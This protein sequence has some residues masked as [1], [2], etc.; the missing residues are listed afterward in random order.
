MTDHQHSEETFAAEG[1]L[2]DAALAAAA[3]GSA[4]AWDG[5]DH[6]AAEGHLQRCPCALARSQPRT[7]SSRH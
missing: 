7:A 3:S 1:H 2:T 4:G 5:L 6:T